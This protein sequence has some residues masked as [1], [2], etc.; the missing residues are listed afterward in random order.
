MGFAGW[1]SRFLRGASSAPHDQDSDQE[2]KPA[3]T[4]RARIRPGRSGWRA[5]F[6]Y[7]TKYGDRESRVIHDWRSDAYYVHGHCAKRDKVLTF[8]KERIEDW[9]EG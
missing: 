9:V 1:L 2:R 5:T 8:K 4:G 6:T 7:S 3:A